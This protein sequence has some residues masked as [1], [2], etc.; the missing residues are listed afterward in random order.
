MNRIGFI[1]LRE[2]ST[3]IEHKNRMEFLGKRLYQWVLDAALRSNLDTIYIFTDDPELA[4][5]C[6]AK[7]EPFNKIEIVPRP[8]NTAT[9]KASTELAMKRFCEYLDWDFDEIYL[10]Q[11]TSPYL[12]EENINNAI[13]LM[14][15]EDLDSV[16]TVSVQKRFLWEIDE[17]G[18]YSPV[19]YGLGNRPFS[20]EMGTERSIL[21]ENGA[22]YATRCELFR[23]SNLRVFG[24]IGIVKMEEHEYLELDTE[25]DLAGL[26]AII[27]KN[28]R[29]KGN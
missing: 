26:K 10:M 17:K 7:Y 19:N 28:E 25:K 3:R 29:G 15:R 9:D 11:A 1:P 21:V 4:S 27:K 16:L 8:A 2:G 23:E 24:N 22:L 18:C 20:Q 14:N 5:D 12:S 6:K 13:R